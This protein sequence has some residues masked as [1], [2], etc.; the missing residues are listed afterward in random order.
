MLPCLF[1]NFR[2]ESRCEKITTM[3]ITCKW[4]LQKSALILFEII[5][6]TNIFEGWSERHQN[7]IGIATG[8]IWSTV[9]VCYI[10][11]RTI[12]FTW[13][14]VLCQYVYKILLIISRNPRR[15]CCVHFIKISGDLFVAVGKVMHWTT[16]TEVTDNFPKLCHRCSWR[17]C[18]RNKK[19]S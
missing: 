2:S 19:H 14:I 17:C 15:W 11:N 4:I 10:W 1:G 9:S 12:I 13:S 16:V 5:F 6:S 8:W 7:V 3:R 18:V